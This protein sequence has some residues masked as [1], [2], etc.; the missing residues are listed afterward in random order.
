M[1]ALMAK[2]I[3]QQPAA[4]SAPAEAELVIDIAIFGKEDFFI[5]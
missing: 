5:A 4:N 1:D 2:V 3:D